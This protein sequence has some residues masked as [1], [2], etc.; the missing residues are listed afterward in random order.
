VHVT[1]PPEETAPPDPES[2]ADSS[3]APQI[4]PGTTQPADPSEL[5]LLEPKL[6]QLA[7]ENND[8]DARRMG[9]IVGAHFGTGGSVEHPF[10]MQPG[11]CYSIVATGVPTVSELDLQL[12]AMSPVPG[13]S[14]VL[15]VDKTTGVDTVLGAKPNCFKWALPMAAPVKLVVTVTGGSGLAAAQVYER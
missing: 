9:S 5:G 14:P 10:Q 12:T 1:V 15:A 3:P 13:M 4:A 11:K 2:S 7:A 8:G 6:N